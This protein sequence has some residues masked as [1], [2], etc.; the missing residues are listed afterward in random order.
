MTTSTGTRKERNVQTR[1]NEAITEADKEFIQSLKVFA[2]SS[3]EVA[4][5]AGA[6]I[7]NSPKTPAG[8]YLAR[9]GD[10]M[11][12]P[13]ALGPPVDFRV[14]IDAN[15][16]IDIGQ[17]NDNA[18]YSSNIELDAIQ[19]NSFVLNI[20]ANAN[21]DG[22][23][24]I[25]RTFGPDSFTI[26]QGDLGNGGNIQTPDGEDFI[27]VALQMV[28][29]VFDEAL[30]LAGNTGGTWRLLS[31]AGGGTTGTGTFISADL[32]ADQTSNIAVNDHVEFDRNAAPT[33]ADGGIV[34]QTG[35]GQANGIFELIGGK[36]YFLSAQVSPIKSATT[37]LVMAWYDITNGNEI[38]RRS[39]YDVDNVLN[40][41]NQPNNQIIFT[42]ATDV[43]VELRI[44]AISIPA[45]LGGFF[46]ITTSAHIF[47]F[48]G[49]NGVT[50]TTGVT[51]WKLPARAKST[52]DIPDLNAAN[53]IFDAIT[54]V[55]G[56]RVLLT[57]QTDLS[58][59]GLYIV[60]AVAA[61][62]APLT[63]P[64]DF[65]TSDE[66]LSETFVAIEEGNL[67]KNEVWHLITNNPI[68][69]DVTDQN[70]NQFAPGTSGGPNMGGGE[71]GID[72]A[73]EWV[74]DGRAGVAASYLKIWEIIDITGNVPENGLS[75]MIYLPTNA[76][77]QVGRLF[78]DGLSNQT[79][80]AGYSDD[81]GETWTL[82]AS[83]TSNLGHGALAYAPNL[84][85][86]G[87][88]VMI[89]TIASSTLAVFSMQ[90]STDRGT[91][92]SNITL[93]FSNLGQNF[94]DVIWSEEEQLFVATSFFDATHGVYTSTDGSSWTRRVTPASSF[95]VN[96]AWN[97]IV[98]SP[99]LG[100]YYINGPGRDI[101]SN[102]EFIEST[103]GIIWTGPTAN[104]EQCGTPSR[105]IWSE[106][107]QKFG[108]AGALVFGGAQP[109]VEFSDDFITWVVQNPTNI[110]NGVDDIVWCPDI[111]LWVIIGDNVNN[112][113]DPRIFWASNDGLTWSNFPV[114]NFRVGASL[115]V[116]N[117]KSEIIYAQEF[118]YFFGVNQGF[119]TGERLFRTSMKLG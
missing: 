50:P 36:T 107:Q 61:G 47:E 65:D 26:N 62:F 51:T 67:F 80:G 43:N 54:L 69:I 98:H 84:T 19:P 25:M 45:N 66:V 32:I 7:S 31:S 91:T 112:T 78:L 115:G 87:T 73:G 24:L 28:I 52:Q 114:R 59:N 92:F 72:G 70:W 56:D 10:S 33:G 38:G 108:A 103:D 3:N 110:Q 35:A 71:D 16:T 95:G 117:S 23:I 29:L 116:S 79:K 102:T 60:G 5:L 63:R 97:K 21:F 34:L 75:S 105:I 77:N 76:A 48:S 90:V 1:A 53:V 94:I 89:R 14:E 17:F 18:H 118:G 2:E 9:E 83:V 11:I 8:N 81:Y 104:N 85:T 49:Q 64:A 22:Q 27:L 82:A 20:I 44:I 30:V 40:L 119:G 113:I 109:I 39:V 57:E 96:F 37:Q 58:E 4:G 86:N 13:I 12:G 88:L 55:E 111:S 99:S 6:A 101:N 41:D 106:G 46:A 100:K 42:P 74:Y 93:D 68:T 15:D